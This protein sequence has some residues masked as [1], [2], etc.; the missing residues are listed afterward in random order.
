MNASTMMTSSVDI[1]GSWKVQLLRISVFPV[2]GVPVTEPSSWWE[3][4]VGSTPDSMTNKPKEGLVQ[5]NGKIDETSQL[6][7]NCQPDRIDWQI[8]PIENPEALTEFPEVG[9]F[10]TVLPKFVGI[11]NGWVEQSCPEL[12]RFAF[13]AVL[14][15]QVSDRVSGY[16][17]MSRFLPDVKIDPEGS[18][19]FSYSINRPR[20]TT[21]NIEG[22]TINRL[23]KWAVVAFK[24]FKI[25]MVGSDGIK[26]FMHA[27]DK[28]TY[29]CRLELDV[30]T[31]INMTSLPKERLKEIFA[32]LMQLA[33]EIAAKGDVK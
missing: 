33:T 32:E 16:K 19:D 17:E 24:L 14:V 10:E 1:S 12:Q 9:D 13:G 4:T 25:P 31:A 3:T 2:N 15:K 27:A 23:S 28:E 20:N 8:S 21:L 30:N 29:L 11:V 18:T 26:L 22:L 5:L 7:L 6:F